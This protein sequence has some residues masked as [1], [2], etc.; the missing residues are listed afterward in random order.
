MKSASG[1]G[2]LPAL[3]AQSA[4]S[5]PPAAAHPR[6]DLVERLDHAGLVIDRLH[7]DQR[8]PCRA[9]ISRR[10]RR[11]RPGPLVD[12]PESPR[13][14]A[15]AQ[16]RLMLDR[17]DEP[18]AAPAPARSPCAIASVAPQVKI[19]SPSQP[20]PR[21]SAPRASSSAAAR[22]A[23]LGMR[24]GGI[25]PAIAARRPSPPPP[26]AGSASSRHGRDRCAR[27]HRVSA[28][29][30]IAQAARAILYRRAPVRGG[31]RRRHS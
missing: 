18:A 15:R 29:L 28:T 30:Q 2:S 9:A 10:A 24:R 12:R 17:G 19:S 26:R 11:D 23:A 16:H 14:P 3:C 20:A 27:S 31:I 7:R 1:S 13:R 5:S 4:S 6:G 25:G 21:R 22:R 8:T